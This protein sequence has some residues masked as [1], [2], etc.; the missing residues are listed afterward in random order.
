MV[1]NVEIA[2]NFLMYNLAEKLLEWGLEW[3][4]SPTLII[5]YS[6][7]NQFLFI[8]TFIGD[9]RKYGKTMNDIFESE[10][11]QHRN[12]KNHFYEK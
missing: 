6:L 10:T 1:L 12:E 7:K 2:I 9:I 11:H 5:L 4:L 8:T 3:S